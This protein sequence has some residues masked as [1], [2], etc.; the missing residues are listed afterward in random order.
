MCYIK[1][2]KETLNYLKNNKLDSWTHNKSIQK[3]RES[4]QVSDNEK[5]ELKKW[6]K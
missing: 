5:N 1:Y 6:K 4:R 2:P 3:I